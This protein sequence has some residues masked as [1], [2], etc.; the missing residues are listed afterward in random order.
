[1]NKKVSELIKHLILFP[2][3]QVCKHYAAM[4]VIQHL[5]DEPSEELVKSIINGDDDKALQ[6]LKEAA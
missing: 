2:N 3:A 1:M 4:L 5:V 6:V